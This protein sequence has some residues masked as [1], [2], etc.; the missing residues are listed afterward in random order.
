MLEKYKLKIPET[1]Q[2]LIEVAKEIN[3]TDFNQDNEPDYALCIDVNPG[4]ACFF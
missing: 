2:E 3:G 1:W 4:D